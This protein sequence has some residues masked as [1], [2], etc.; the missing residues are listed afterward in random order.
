MRQ[1][2]A[3]RQNTVK[4]VPYEQ[5]Q[6]RK[7]NID[8]AAYTPPKP[9]FLGVKVFNNYP[10]T[11]LIDYI[12]W[13]PF[14]LSWELAGKFPDILTDTVVGEAATQLYADAQICLQK[15]IDNN[16][17]Q[18]DAAIGFGLPTAKQTI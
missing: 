10:L 9:A 3:N 13:T 11:D 15:I 6:T 7:F 16:W 5:A 2:R 14:F 12:D 4:L 1:R 8:W 17:V 18:A